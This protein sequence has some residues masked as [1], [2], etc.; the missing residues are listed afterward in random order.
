MPE[1]VLGAVVED[2]EAEILGVLEVL[3]AVDECCERRQFEQHLSS[4]VPQG[5]LFPK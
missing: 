1:R 4:F 5:V 3:E 2:L